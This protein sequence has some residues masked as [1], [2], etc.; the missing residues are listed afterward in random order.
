M[1]PERLKERTTGGTRKRTS[2]TVGAAP[3][4]P[5]KHKKHSEISRINNV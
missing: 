3:L 5:H 2:V 4:H 1:E